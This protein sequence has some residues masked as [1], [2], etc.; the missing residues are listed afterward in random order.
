MAQ[1]VADELEDLGMNVVSIDNT[2]EDY[3][4]GDAVYK[5]A[6]EG[7]KTATSDKLKELYSNEVKQ[8]TP[9]FVLDTEADFV[10]IVSE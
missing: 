2:P 3:S 1:K 4:G 5:I 7:Q 9:P 10:V 6:G 8:G